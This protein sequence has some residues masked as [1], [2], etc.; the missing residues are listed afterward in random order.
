MGISESFLELRVADASKCSMA[1]F[2]LKSRGVILGTRISNV[3]GKLLTR[4]SNRTAHSTWNSLT[5]EEILSK[6]IQSVSSSFRILLGHIHAYRRREHK[7]FNFL[8]S[9]ICKSS[10]ARCR[11]RYL[12]SLVPY[13][14][15]LV[16]WKGDHIF[17]VDLLR[18]FY[19]FRENAKKSFRG[20]ERR[21]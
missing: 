13:W 14:R 11:L 18:P 21:R 15:S 8:S 10:Y 4:V 6:E 9:L 3:T 12:R 17:V 19:H 2:G 7:T 20:F 16:R 1:R 5:R